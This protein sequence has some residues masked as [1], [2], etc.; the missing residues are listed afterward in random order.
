MMQESIADT[1]DIIHNNRFRSLVTSL[2]DGVQT[3][4]GPGPAPGA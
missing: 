1:A 3:G 2:G 4:A